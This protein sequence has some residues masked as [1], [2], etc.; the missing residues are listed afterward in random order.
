M[1]VVKKIKLGKKDIYA[2][3]DDD[4][5]VKPEYCI[6]LTGH[7]YPRANIYRG[8]INGKY[9]YDGIYLHHLVMGKPPKGLVT[10]HIN[11]N[12]LDNRKSNLRFIPQSSNAINKSS[13][14]NNKSGYRGVHFSKHNTNNST[15][16]VWVAQ[17]TTNYKCR[18]LGTFKTAKQ[19]ALAYDKAAKELHGRYA[20]LNFT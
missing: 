1:S 8:K 2:I 10:D 13:Q 3:V 18:H 11:R 17:I 5:E 12:R 20:C 15:G 19:A 4:F 9:K 14:S 7:G 6:S 16:K